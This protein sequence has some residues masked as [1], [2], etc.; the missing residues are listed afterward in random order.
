MQDNLTRLQRAAQMPRPGG[1]GATCDAVQQRRRLARPRCSY[2][3]YPP[4]AGGVAVCAAGLGSGAAAGALP[5]G[6][7]RGAGV[8]G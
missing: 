8:L 2:C 1:M 6:A 4:V 3:G 5:T 7:V